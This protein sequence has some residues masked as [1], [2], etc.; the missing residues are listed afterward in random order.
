MSQP[1]HLFVDPAQWN[2]AHGYGRDNA[3]ANVVHNDIELVP[4]APFIPTV[5]AAA[6]GL[7]SARPPYLPALMPYVPLEVNPLF[8]T[9]PSVVTLYL[10]LSEDLLATNL[11]FRQ[12]LEAIEAPPAARPTIEG[13]AYLRILKSSLATSLGPLLPAAIIPR[14]KRMLLTLDQIVNM[15]VAGELEVPIPSGHSIGQVSGNAGFRVITTRGSFDP[16]YFYD[17]MRA[18][19]DEGPAAV[20]AFLA[21]VPKTWPLFSA[22]SKAQVLQET[23]TSIF[24]MDVLLDARTRVTLTAAEWRTVGNN[25]KALWREQLMQRQGVAPAGSTAPRFEFVDPQSRNVFQLEALTEFYANFDDPWAAGA[26]PRQ[27][28]SPGYV[29]VDFLN[30]AGSAAVAV[31]DVVTLDGTSDLSRGRL[32]Q[33]PSGAAA[34]VDATDGKILHLDGTIRL[35]RVLA[36]RDYLYLENASDPIRSFLIT[37]VNLAN[38]TVTL[39]QAPTLSQVSSAWQINLGNVFRLLHLQS[40]PTRLYRITSIHPTNRTVTV[41]GTPAL[42]GGSSA[43]EIVVAPVVVL[44]DPFGHR[45]SGSQATV[46]GSVVTLD[47]TP[48]KVNRRFDTIFLE[49]DTA[50]PSRTYRIQAVNDVAKT[51]TVSGN[52]VLNG[53]SSAWRIPGGIG[54]ALPAYYYDLTGSAH[55]FDHYLGVA[56]LVHSDIVRRA[57]AAA[58]QNA[59]VTGPFRFTSYSSR[60]NSDANYS[61]IRGNSHYH[62]YSFLSGDSYKNFTFAVTD[63]RSPDLVAEARNYFG[64]T[65]GVIDEGAAVTDDANGKDKIRFHNGNTSGRAGTG[66]A[67]CIVHNAGFHGLRTE[68]ARLYL[69]EHNAMNPG[70][71]DTEVQHVY[72]AADAASSEALYGRDQ[73]GWLNKVRATLWLIRPEERAIGP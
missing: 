63:P 20:D 59:L 19:V 62:V 23:A 73:G 35:N 11:P 37:G 48:E 54:G 2:L 70:A 38:R 55:G 45:Q 44:I 51:V 67:G 16:S 71:P 12:R 18:F 65:V 3:Q 9:D 4:R 41:N 22:T 42:A 33:K 52:P 58:V 21:L 28:G 25:Q 6:T 32:D 27:P 26:Q 29:R 14:K 50:R 24:P 43:W 15:L 40:D 68:M 72:E 5:T 30:P 31:A 64:G 61:S 66:S 13:F 60:Y 69:A 17:W 1:L 8:Q 57:G 53:S 56:F 39:Q 47:R 36:N 7:L 49:A 34:T 10:H 46:A